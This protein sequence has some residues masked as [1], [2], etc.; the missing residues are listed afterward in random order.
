[1]KKTVC[2]ILTLL[3]LVSVSSFTVSA[4]EYGD[5]I[6][7]FP[8]SIDS[9]SFRQPAADSTRIDVEFLVSGG[10]EDDDDYFRDRSYNYIVSAAIV[11]N[12]VIEGMRPISEGRAFLGNLVQI[13]GDLSN[14]NTF[15]SYSLVLEV[16]KDFEGLEEFNIA[17]ADGTFSYTSAN[18][19]PAPSGFDLI[20]DLTHFAVSA[21]WENYRDHTGDE[22][23]FAV[24]DGRDE[25]F[26]VQ[27]PREETAYVV[28]FDPDATEIT[29]ELSYIRN[30]R[31]SS[32][33]SKTIILENVL[34]FD[35]GE[36]TSALQ[37]KVDYN[38]DRTIYVTVSVF[39]PDDPSAYNEFGQVIVTPSDIIR[40]DGSGFFSINLKEFTN[41]IEIKW[42]YDISEDQ[43]TGT[44]HF[45]KHSDVY[46]DWF[47]PRL[48]L[49]EHSSVIYTDASSFIIAGS[50]DV[51]TLIFI[52]DNAV[53]VDESGSFIYTVSLEHGENLFLVIAENDSGNQTAQ[54]VVIFRT[55]PAS[56]LLAQRESFIDRFLVLI[57]TA[58]AGLVYLIC[59]PLF[60]KLY[61][62]KQKRIEAIADLV[63]NLC[64]PLFV[65]S[66]GYFAY[67]LAMKSRIEQYV[68]SRDFVY[69]VLADSGS[70]IDSVIEYQQRQI[71][72]EQALWI[73]VAVSIVFAATLIFSILVR[74]FGKFTK[75][76]PKQKPPKPAQTVEAPVYDEPYVYEEPQSYV[77]PQNYYVEPQPPV[78]EEPPSYVEPQNYYVEPQPP[79]QNT[80]SPSYCRNCG[81]ALPPN[82]T[83]CGFCGNR[84]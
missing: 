8:L 50:T 44:I 20:I 52:S 3:I 41:H 69:D 66:A 74:L 79:V 68:N 42:T 26:F 5:I 64:T 9:F 28:S 67:S 77:E 13:Q 38:T 1:M 57:V 59:V 11:N 19:L 24:L 36:H 56:E 46:V 16:F 43:E 70:V 27:L 45:I 51:G 32:V 39:S 10:E 55:D 30:G 73:F 23:I 63:R 78:Y 18:M 82:A 7:M 17:I 81:E 47:P 71:Q 62:K 60:V 58:A 12:G 22:W 29:V 6:E 48:R 35:F 53:T 61:N 49:P 25:S 21:N 15:G 84:L 72:F 80:D 65:M 37:G 2:T 76:D 83:F 40:L 54:T 34:T 33:L 14:L 31:V 75:K 4:D